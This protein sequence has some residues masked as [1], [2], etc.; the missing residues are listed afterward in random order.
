[1]PSGGVLLAMAM[2]M[3]A[4]TPA[5]ADPDDVIGEWR[6]PA[7]IHVQV[8]HCAEVVCARIVRMPDTTGM[9]LNNP[10]PR[11]R[12]RPILGIQIFVAARA[13]G[14]NGWKGKMYVPETGHTY[15]SRLISLG[16]NRLEVET[17]GPMGFFCTRE[18]WT[19]TR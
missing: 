2:A 1:M 11:L 4:A 15:D 16:R 8:H 10:E 18:V 9:D 19:R 14:P 17:C 7:P 5:L 3:T 6:T 12:P 13:S